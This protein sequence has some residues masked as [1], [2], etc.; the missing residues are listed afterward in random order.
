MV[1]R[2]A[3]VMPA[4]PHHTR[5]LPMQNNDAMFGKFKSLH[6][7]DK[8]VDPKK[9]ELQAGL[10]SKKHNAADVPFK[11]PATTKK[12]SGL[13]DYFGTLEGKVA[14]YAVSGEG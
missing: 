3:T 2:G 1:L 14:Y 5:V 6:E 11:P 4:A 12:S 8:F 7:G 9:R 13:G 10:E